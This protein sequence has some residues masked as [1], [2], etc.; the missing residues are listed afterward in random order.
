VR[1]GGDLLRVQSP[2]EVERGG[3]CHGGSLKDIQ[4]ISDP[5]DE[6]DCVGP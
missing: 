4:D 6:I 2:F 1:D 3:A 5:K